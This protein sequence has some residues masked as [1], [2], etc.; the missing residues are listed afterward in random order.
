MRFLI[1]SKDFLIVKALSLAKNLHNLFTCVFVSYSRA[2][3]P[4][5]AAA[6]Y[7]HSFPH[8]RTQSLDSMSSGHS[9]GDHVAASHFNCMHD[10]APLNAL[11]NGHV[12]KRRVVVKP[13]DDHDDDQETPAYRRYNHLTCAHL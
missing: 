12:A 4:E 2:A 9:S 8:Q 13:F 10:P 7:P 6:E 1:T 3:S 11:A 5:T